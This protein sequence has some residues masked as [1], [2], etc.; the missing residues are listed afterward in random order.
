MKISS[1]EPRQISAAGGATV[2]V[3]G[4]GFG[5]ELQVRVGGV[6]A[7]DVRIDA[8]SS[9][10][11]AAPPGRAGHADLELIGAETLVQRNALLYVAL[12]PPVI[13]SITPNRGPTNGM[14]DVRIEGQN[15][16]AAS[17][18]LVQGKRP[19][20]II[21]IDANTLEIMPPPGTDGQ[22]ADITVKNPDG[23]QVTMQRAFLYDGRFG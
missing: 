21:L 2:E 6:P 9:L 12:P 5:P 4:S 22:F 8:G 16:V 1:V 17:Q 13:R 11:F 10:R 20:S 19:L 15:F 23:S 3:S 14:I 7:R 18:V